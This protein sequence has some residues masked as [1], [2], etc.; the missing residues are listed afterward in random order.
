MKKI[1]SNVSLLLFSVLATAQPLYERSFSKRHLTN[2]HVVDFEQIQSFYG[3]RTTFASSHQQS[4]TPNF[5]PIDISDMD[6]VISGNNF[7]ILE[8]IDNSPTQSK[9]SPY[10]EEIFYSPGQSFLIDSVR[11]T[12]YNAEFEEQLSF[13]VR[14]DTLPVGTNA[15]R[16]YPIYSRGMFSSNTNTRDFM[17]SV[18]D[19]TPPMSPQTQRYSCWVVNEHGEMIHRFDMVDAVD[20]YRSGNTRK[21]ITSQYKYNAHVITNADTSY[22]D[23]WS[24][25]GVNANGPTGITLQATHSFGTKNL[26][27]MEAPIFDI[28]T[29]GNNTY[30]YF[31]YYQYPYLVG[32]P[33]EGIVTPN[34]VGI[35]ELFNINNSNLFKQIELPMPNWTDAAQLSFVDLPEY[36]ITRGI[37]TQGDTLSVLYGMRHY[38]VG[39][40]DCYEKTLHVATEFGEIIRNMDTRLNTEMQSARK[41]A[42]I[43]GYPRQYALVEAFGK[44]IVGFSMFEPETWTVVTRFTPLMD[45]ERIS[46]YFDRVPENGGY[47][48][49]M[50]MFEFLHEG[51]T[52][53]AKINVYNNESNVLRDIKLDLGPNAT[54]FHPILREST[55]N[56]FLFSK[57][58]K[59]EFIGIVRT[60]IGLNSTHSGVIFSEDGEQ[61]Y[62]VRDNPTMGT[63]T[64][65]G[66]LSVD[67]GKT[68]KYLTAAYRKDGVQTIYLYS[69]PFDTTLT[70][71][72]EGTLANPYLIHDVAELDAIREN[73]HAHYRIMN[74][75]DMTPLLGYRTWTPIPTFTGTLDGQNFAIRN[76]RFENIDENELSAS[77]FSRLTG[78]AKIENLYITDAEIIADNLGISFVAGVMEGSALIKNVH[79]TGSIKL[80]TLFGTSN[81]G[82]IV[83]DVVSTTTVRIEQCSFDGVIETLSGI[84]FNNA[85]IGGIAGSLRNAEVINS[86]SRGRI[87]VRNGATPTSGVG[88]IVGSM[89]SNCLISNCYSNMDIT[90]TNM[91]GGVVGRADEAQGGI[92][93]TIENSYASGRI[94]AQGVNILPNSGTFAGGVIGWSSNH[95][96]HFSGTVVNKTSLT[97]GGLVALNDTVTCLGVDANPPSDLIRRARRIIGINANSSSNLTSFG[98][99]TLDSIR[100]CYA[101]AAM[102]IGQAGVEEALTLADASHHDGADVTVAELTQ[103]FFTNIGWKFG[104]NADNPWVWIEDAYPMLW[105]EVSVQ[106]VTLN[107]EQLTLLEG[108]THQL[109]A[110]VTPTIAVNQNVTWNSDNTNIATVDE[111]GSVAAVARGV[112]TITVTTVDGGFTATCVVTVIPE[113][114]AITLSA[115]P[116]EGGS[117][118]GAGSYDEGDLVEVTATPNANYTFVNWTENGAE[119]STAATFTFTAT[120]DRTLVANFETTSSIQIAENQNLFTVYPNPV[121]DVL[122]I[123]TEQTIKQI[124]ILDLNGKVMMQLQGD[125]KTVDLQS[126]PSGNYIVRIHTETAIVPVKIV[127]Q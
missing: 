84:S 51:G 102:A 75:I 6:V 46:E 10:T 12:L 64:A 20:I 119:I 42:D 89:R 78:T 65:F 32:S 53:K 52:T 43:P 58:S 116:A 55:L 31:L 91:V 57:S 70:L 85:H 108:E 115:N 76:L 66:L 93:G 19:W 98:M 50:N 113:T 125:R 77:L 34:N 94:I 82:A 73:P 8:C 106:S 5:S 35:L 13:V 100:N 71:Q 18:H 25:T 44:A 69:L 38:A 83:A 41:L 23:I 48:Y 2:S 74:D 92:K 11:Y 105:F 112:A 126:I 15:V 24:I 40:C 36:D 81:V 47:V 16:I 22:F 30:Y 28:K 90:A 17:I 60:T 107:E 62:V 111:N 68:Q 9:Y 122:H 1:L 3:E 88:G 56:P 87:T 124:F 37:F 61:L 33:A 14:T 86:V 29:I 45:G 99:L 114:Y 104:D 109:V 121:D 79:V 120:R 103:D 54:L 59:R 26:V 95:T 117:V 118:L 63:A 80:G 7:R 67:G 49:Y 101:L 110:T 21:V 123:Q 97:M 4:S 127:K 39:V 27:A 96:G 72:G